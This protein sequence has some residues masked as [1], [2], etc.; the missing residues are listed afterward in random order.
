MFFS[1][2]SLNRAKKLVALE[3]SYD[4]AKP[5]AQTIWEMNYVLDPVAI[6]QTSDKQ[7]L[8]L[9]GRRHFPELEVMD[10]KTGDVLRWINIQG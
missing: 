5:P 6:T 3:I 8:G 1:L 4:P 7:L 2:T 9:R 10:F